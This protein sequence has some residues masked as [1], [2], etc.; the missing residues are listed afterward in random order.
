MQDSLW[1]VH[2]T[3]LTHSELQ[4]AKQPPEQQQEPLINH[5][6]KWALK[7]TILLLQKQKASLY[8]IITLI[9][10]GMDATNYSPAVFSAYLF[11]FIFYAVFS[12]QFL[13][14]SSNS[15]FIQ[16]LVL[17]FPKQSY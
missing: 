8:G 16:I 5:S 13:N 12:S 1:L 11:G 4:K 15:V 6:V 9:I 14:P 17:Y 3:H 2:L 10:L 7:P